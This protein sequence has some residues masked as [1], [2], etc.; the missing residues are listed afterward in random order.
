MLKSLFESVMER[1]ARQWSDRVA[2]WLPDSGPVL[3]LGSGTGHLSRRVEDD[4]GVRT[5]PADVVDIHVVGRPPVLVADDGLPFDER[6]FSAALMVFMLAYPK[7]PSGLMAEVARVTSGPIIVV[8]T[9]HSGGFGYVWLRVREFMWTLVAFYVSKV[10]GYLPWEAKFSMQTQRFYTQ[11]ALEEDVRTAGLRVVARQ[12]YPIL[13]RTGL[14]VAGY[15]L[16][17]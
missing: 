5:V 11:A 10:V 2:P 6:A 15:L 17:S 7:N 16:R 9:L 13:P 3:D 12:E 4:A 14:R 8:Q 1:R